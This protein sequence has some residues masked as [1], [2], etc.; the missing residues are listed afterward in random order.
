MR[1][2]RAPTLA[3]RV[4]LAF[5]SDIHVDM[6]GPD[7]LDLLAARVRAT[8]P[9][10]LVVAGDVATG[11]ATW[12]RTLLAL[13]AEVPELLV[14]AGNHDVWSAP[15]AVAAGID[16]WTRLDRVLPALCAEAGARYLEKGPV[17]L[18]GV[19]FAG[20][21]GWFDLSLR[22]PHLDAPDEAYRSGTWGGVRWND[23]HL[24]VWRDA[25]GAPEPVERV[26]A[27]LRDRL[28]A[29]LDALDTPRIV[30]VTHVLPFAAQVRRDAPPA[31]RFVNAFMGSTALGELLLGDPR[32]VLAIA[33]HTHVPSDLRIGGLRAVVS[34][35]GYRKEWG[36]ASPEAAVARALQVVE[37]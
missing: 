21:M 29:H 10:V 14:V 36:G 24:A 5:T 3:G 25:D 28:A 26:A 31:W 34:P 35:L 6:N 11:A 23:H 12:M 9:D 32:V 22:D 19:G 30:A 15:A 16:A 2:D 27:R 13:K 7:V 33:G 18:D 4:R 8:A 1:A 17:V 20:T 37:L